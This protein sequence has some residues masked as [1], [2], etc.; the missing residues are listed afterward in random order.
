MVLRLQHPYGKC[1]HRCQ[2][3]RARTPVV[4]R[5]SDVLKQVWF[6]TETMF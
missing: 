2:S 3:E 1:T 6:Q 4:P 5:S